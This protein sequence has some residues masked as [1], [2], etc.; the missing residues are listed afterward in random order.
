MVIEPSAVAADGYW[1]DNPKAFI[2]IG[3]NQ[4]TNDQMYAILRD[5]YGNWVGPADP[6]TWS[7]ANTSVVTAS[8]GP[9]GSLGQGTATRVTSGSG[10]T[11]ITAR[12]NQG[13]TDD[14]EARVLNITYDELRI[15]VGEGGTYQVVDVIEIRTDRDTTLFVQ[16]KR[17][18]NGEWEDIDA[19]WQ[20]NV[21]LLPSAPANQTHSWS[22]S[23][24]ST[25]NGRVTASTNGSGGATISDAVTLIITHGPPASMVFYPAAGD[26][27]SLTPLTDTIT[28]TAGGSATIAA[29]LFDNQGEWL[30]KYETVDSLKNRIEWEVSDEE[31]AAIAPLVG[32]IITFTS[33]VA[34]AFYDVRATYSY[35]GENITEKV[36]VKVTPAEPTQLVIEPNEN[37][38]GDSP[39]QPNPFRGDT[40]Q[41][42]EDMGFRRAFAVLRDEYGNFV[43]FSGNTT[44]DIDDPGVANVEKGIE[45]QGEGIVRRVTAEGSTELTVRDSETGLTTTVTVDVKPYYYK[46]L[47]IYVK[48]VS[49]SLIDS[50]VM[51][52]VEDTVL[53]VLGMRSDDTT[54]W[55]PV[56]S[57]QWELVDEIG[58]IGPAKEESAWTLTPSDTG[59]VLLSVS[60]DDDERT[61]SDSVWVHIEPDQSTGAGFSSNARRRDTYVGVVNGMLVVRGA[62]PICVKLLDVRGRVIRTLTGTDMRMQ[63][64]PAGLYILQHEEQ[65]G[66]RRRRL[67]WPGGR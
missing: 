10:T 24:V 61:A 38:R 31:N 50:L 58:T 53:S 16:G 52:V 34:H 28:I 8:A 15:V 17:S 32:N 13:F 64:P 36:V 60:L 21:T 43:G 1:D 56:S 19:A 49:D 55:E 48:G 29:K 6:A 44:W 33:T 63:M 18:D 35:A 3:A 40:I 42:T 67:L 20:S 57:V 66:I 30:A 51:M 39:N 62:A 2:Q 22:F 54:R 46:A 26:P 41:V 25:G 23:P 5:V 27:A 12:S 59:R 65:S 9:D 7:S 45:F 47:Q 4:T 14:I 37:G 11:S